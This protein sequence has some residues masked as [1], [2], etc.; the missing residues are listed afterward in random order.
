MIHYLILPIAAVFGAFGRRIAGGLLNEIF[1]PFGPRVFGDIPARLIFGLAIGAAFLL[2]GT[3]PLVATLC[4]VAVYIGSTTGNRDGIDLGR[5]EGTFW[6]DF[7][8]LSLHGWDSAM[9]CLVLAGWGMRFWPFL[10]GCM[11]IAPLYEVGYRIGGTRVVGLSKPT[12][13]GE[14]LWG[15]AMGIGAF[16][17]C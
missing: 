3:P 9:A 12:E 11:L 6:Q 1:R 14:A 10:L 16:L 7:G 15:A 8:N 17:A 4:V 5:G 13:I 2:G